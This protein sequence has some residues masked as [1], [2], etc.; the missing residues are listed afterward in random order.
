MR[1]KL[2]TVRLALFS[3]IFITFFNV[4]LAISKDKDLSLISEERK[5]FM[6]SEEET[7]KGPS[8]FNDFLRERKFLEFNEEKWN[9][10]REK[11]EEGIFLKEKK[12]KRKPEKAAPLLKEEE[13]EGLIEIPFPYESQ[14]KISGRKA[15]AIKGE[16]VKYPK[17]KD[18]TSMIKS[19]GA[20]VEMEQE[21]QVRIKGKVGRKVTVDVDYDDTKENKRDISVVY[22][23]DPEEIVQE[24]AF[25]D[26]TLSLP[27]TEFVSYNKNVFGIKLDAKYK[28]LE[29]MAIGSR[30]KGIT[31]VKRFKGSTT[32]EKKDIKDIDYVK[33]KYYKLEHSPIQRES[34][35]VWIDF[36]DGTS[37]QTE[38]TNK[39]MTV[40]VWNSATTST[41]FFDKQFRGQDYTVDYEKGIITF[42]KSIASN[43]VIVVDYKKTD[44]VKVSSDNDNKY[45]MIKDE[46][47]TLNYELKNYYGLGS[48]KIIKKYDEDFILKILNLSR[49]EQNLSNYEIDYID[50][51]LGIIKFKEDEPFPAS[52]YDKSKKVHQYIIYVEYK[53]RVKSYQLRMDIVLNSERVVMNNRLLQK[54]KDY[55]IDYDTGWITFFNEEDIDEDT[56]IEITYEYAPFGG[57]SQQ[58]LVGSRLQYGINSDPFFIGSTVMWSGTDKPSTAPSVHSTPQSIL[59]LDADSSVSIEHEKFPLKTTLSGEIAR[60]EFNPNL[61]NKALIDNMEGIKL[62]DGIPMDKDLWQ[63]ASTPSYEATGDINTVTLK[64]ALDWYNEDVKRKEIVE[65][66]NP[67]WVEEIG[68]SE[69]VEVLVLKY[70]LKDIDEEASIVYPISRVGLDYSKKMFL[71]M[72]IYGDGGGEE[73]EVHLGGISENA[74]GRGVIGGQPKTEDLNNDGILN[75]GEDKG[76]EFIHPDGSKT[77]IGADNGLIDT[78]D[79][80]GDNVLDDK[81]STGNYY[82]RTIDWSGW[83]FIKIPLDI[84][85]ESQWIAIKHIRLTLRNKQV[86]LKY[87]TVRF[88][89]I[90]IVGTKWDK[91]AKEDG[92]FDTGEGECL[93][94]KAI[95]NE[96]DE[97]YEDITDR[98]EYD[99]LYRS[100]ITGK[101]KEQALALSYT[102]KNNSAAYTKTTFMSAQDYSRYKRIKFFLFG[103][104]GNGSL[105]QAKGIT[106]YIQ[107]GVDDAN[108]YQYT[109]GEVNWTGWKVFDICLDEDKNGDNIPDGFNET[110]GNPSLNNIKQIKLVVKNNDTGSKISDG[111]IWINEIFVEGIE[112]KEG[113]AWKSAI[114]LELPKWFSVR[115]NHKEIDSDFETVTTGSSKQDLIS[116]RSLTSGQD[117]KSESGSLAFTRFKFLPLSFNINREETKTPSSYDTPYSSL[118]EGKVESISGQGSAGLI[119]PRLP[120]LEVSYSEDH[121]ESERILEKKDTIN[122]KSSL[123]YTI[124]HKFSLF[125]PE[126]WKVNL[127]PS[128]IDISYGRKDYTV[129]KTTFTY[130]YKD[131]T[132]NFS[133]KIPFV[134]WKGFSFAPS[135]SLEIIKA[136]EEGICEN[137]NDKYRSQI[138]RLDSNLRFFPWLNPDFKY[139]ITSSGTYD[140]YKDEIETITRNSDGEL[141]CSLMFKKLLPNFVPLHSLNTENSYKVE[142]GDSY[143]IEDEEVGKA[144]SIWNS[145]KGLWL[146]DERDKLEY[147]FPIP[148]SFSSRH[149]RK[150]MN[151]WEPFNFLGLGERFYPL[152]NMDSTI[153]YSEISD[154]K[155]TTGSVL[156]TITKTWPDLVLDIQDIENFFSLNKFISNS[157]VSINYSQKTVEKQDISKDI[158][159]KRGT[160]WRFSMFRDYSVSFEYDDIHDESRNIQD[161]N[162]LTRDGFTREVGLQVGLSL[163][164]WR[165]TPRYEYSSQQQENEVGEKTKGIIIHSPSLKIYADLKTPGL[166]IPYIGFK[167]S[168][169]VVVDTLLKYERKEGIEEKK[170][171]TDTYSLDI[172]G[173]YDTS[174]NLKV[175]LGFGG[176]FFNN[177]KKEEDN[178][179]SISLSGNLSI[180]F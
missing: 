39:Q 101:R 146:F 176:S 147:P 80:D 110:K 114:D 109:T 84:T 166:K 37:P 49:E 128:D 26:I 174:E 124:P 139:Q 36:K 1:R 31:E 94:V 108:Y 177:R 179:W 126:A 72:S 133:G 149:T 130:A 29:L 116:T 60:S 154:Y 66:T 170:D 70:N 52:V 100:T 16:W 34:E 120:K 180:I 105:P 25:G 104:K 11:K 171:N 35:E 6:F 111:E 160:C 127:L 169:R 95:N 74:D 24:A 13:K 21:L 75:E 93:I 157:Q 77:L 33:K 58:T 91:G 164:E 161:S 43:Y 102:L 3:L 42:R 76:W 112:K 22:K 10:M 90:G 65:N 123:N 99:S 136:K 118:E 46:E 92:S 82:T 103:G 141:S 5:V 2:K 96:D 153:N 152:K 73:L 61:F 125:M 137:F 131:L 47:D 159:N 156:K 63:L 122:K 79:L 168:N 44:G 97:D 163:N 135:Y 134:P 23:G 59:V 67:N 119:V 45:M 4:Y 142:A 167:L 7:F 14:L 48:T 12:E 117:V 165:F 98:N 55:M 155:E 178:Y 129:T 69:E 51:D 132:E 53:Y 19:E 68:E 38:T 140:F 18:T 144:K 54:D 28:R 57:Q 148:K 121:S 9:R 78:E 145:W 113:L 173:S 172:K 150:T 8:D 64:G 56:N 107:F 32:F 71:E 20:N 83:R 151:R 115:A 85:D 86:G 158:T 27:S 175:T 87:G 17:K 50:Y 143:E 41:G 81:N 30:T 40:K 162:K 62:V 89:S 138:I 15:I 106:F 88:S